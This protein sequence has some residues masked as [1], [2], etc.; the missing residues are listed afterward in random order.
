MCFMREVIQ[1][2][3]FPVQKDDAHLGGQGLDDQI[4]Q[5]L[6]PHK[7]SINKNAVISPHLERDRLCEP[8]NHLR[9]YSTPG[10][11]QMTLI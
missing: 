5:V 9:A 8:A 7:P 11:G 4:Y 1:R 3:T 2:S 10:F 6:T